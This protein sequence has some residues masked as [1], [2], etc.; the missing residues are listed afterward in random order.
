MDH[1]C[2]FDLCSVVEGSFSQDCVRRKGFFTFLS[3]KSKD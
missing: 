1:K 3:Q 2:E